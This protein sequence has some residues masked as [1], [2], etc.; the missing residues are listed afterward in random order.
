MSPAYP[1]LVR[2]WAAQREPR[3]RSGFAVRVAALLARFQTDKL[4]DAIRVF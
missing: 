2:Q 1:D 3:K 4:L